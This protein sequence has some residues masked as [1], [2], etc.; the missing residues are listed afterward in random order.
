MTTEHVIEVPGYCSESFVDADGVDVV[1]ELRAGH[2][3]THYSLALSREW[4][5]E[6]AGA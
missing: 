6:R 4:R 5:S 2:D 1:C 3:G